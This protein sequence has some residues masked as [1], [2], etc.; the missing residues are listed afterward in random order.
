MEKVT[1]VQQYE[2]LL[3][4]YDFT[5]DEVAF[6]THEKEKVEKKNA[7]KS[8]ATEKDAAIRA[9]RGEKVLAFLSATPNQIYS[10][11]ELANKVDVG[12]EVCSTSA[13]TAI[14]KPLLEDG[15]VKKIKDKSKVYYQIA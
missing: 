13:M 12:M 10:P 15:K 9:E 3:T 2:N 5:P 7:A 11:T 6:L 4:K 8:K 14:L 1:I